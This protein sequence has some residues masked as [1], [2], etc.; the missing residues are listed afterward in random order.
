MVGGAGAANRFVNAQ[1]QARFVKFHWK[2]LLGTLAPVWE[3]APQLAGKD[4]NWL[5]RDLWETIAQGDYPEFEFG[6]QVLEQEEEFKFDFDVLN[7][8]KIWPEELVPVRR[9]GK[10]TLDRNPDNFFAETEQAAFHPGHV[11][12][13]IDFTNDPLLPG[14]LFSYLDTQLIHLGGPNFAEIPINRP[15]A[16]VHANQ[17]DG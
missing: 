15:L 17:R 1:G 7:A 2:P 10:L 8:T 11:V 12:L 14:R 3:E 4:P 6:I 13:G 5:R 9:I 16:P